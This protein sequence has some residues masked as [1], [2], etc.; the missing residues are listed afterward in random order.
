MVECLLGLR[1]DPAVLSVK[2]IYNFFRLQL[3]MADTVEQ[4]GEASTVPHLGHLLGQ[5]LD[6]QSILFLLQNH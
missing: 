5:I 2:C 1:V 3:H 4:L 6:R